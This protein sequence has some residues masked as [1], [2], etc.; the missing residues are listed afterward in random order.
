MNRSAGL[1]NVVPT[2]GETTVMSTVPLPAGAMAVIKSSLFTVKDVAGVEPKFTAV[3]PQLK[4]DPLIVTA[5]PPAVLPL[6]GLTWVTSKGA[7][8]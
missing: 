3:T 1:V 4:V 7:V 6:L 8:R 5:V 2:I